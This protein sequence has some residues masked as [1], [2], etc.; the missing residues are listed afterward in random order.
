M[1][2]VQGPPGVAPRCVYAT[3][4]PSPTGAHLDVLQRDLRHLPRVPP[5]EERVGVAALVLRQAPGAGAHPGPGGKKTWPARD[6]ATVGLTVY[7]GASRCIPVEVL[8]QTWLSLA[9]AA[10]RYSTITR[11]VQEN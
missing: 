5:L 4:T 10:S 3:Q 1:R 11:T 7:P 9:M 2:R 8:T 6:I